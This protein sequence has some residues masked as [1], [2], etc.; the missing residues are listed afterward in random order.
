MPLG[1]VSYALFLLRTCVCRGQGRFCSCPGLGQYPYPSDQ[2]PRVPSPRRARRPTS[3]STYTRQ[4]CTQAYDAGTVI[5]APSMSMTVFMRTPRV[6]GPV[7]EHLVCP[8][9]SREPLRQHTPS[10]CTRPAPAASQPGRRSA[11]CQ[12]TCP[13]TTPGQQSLAPASFHGVRL[14]VWQ[15]PTRAALRSQKANKNGTCAAT[16]F[17]A[18][19]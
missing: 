13:L 17:P 8:P 18:Y 7:H 2:C 15:K 14:H 5:A 19:Y 9:H 12:P 6:I 16:Y 4:A 1:G 10:P 3:P 11:S